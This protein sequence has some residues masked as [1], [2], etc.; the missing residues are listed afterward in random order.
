MSHFKPQ[1]NHTY[2]QFILILNKAPSHVDSLDA[3]SNLIL[4]VIIVID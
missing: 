4:A 3:L 2:I 1:V